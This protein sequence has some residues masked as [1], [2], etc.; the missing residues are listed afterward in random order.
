M[1]ILKKEYEL[2]VWNEELIDGIKKESRGT[3]I[4][5]S[6]MTH[7]GRATTPKL[8]RSVK[9]TNTLTFQ[10]P[11][12][13]FDSEKGD[14]VK[15][16]L[17]EDLYNERKLKLHYDGDWYEFYVKSIQEDKQFKSIMKTIT[18][19]DSFI[20]ELSRTGYEVEFSSDLNNSVEELGTF[21][22]TE[23]DEKIKG[24]SK[25][26]LDGSVWDYRPD[27]NVG[28]FTEFNEQ[29]FYKIPLSQF[30]GTIKGYKINLEVDESDFKTITEEEEK[31]KRAYL[32]NPFTKEKRPLEYGDDQARVEEL[33]YD[34]YEKDNGR[35]LLSD[36]NL[37]EISGDYIYV[38]ITDLTYIM[39]SVYKSA[40][41]SL[42][43]PAIYGAYNPKA[44]KEIYALQPVSE[45]PRDLIQ[46]LFFNE[47]DEVLIDEEGVVANK[48]CHYLITI[49][50]WN[51][52]LK[53]QLK[54][55]SEGLIHWTSPVQK[56]TETYTLNKLYTT[57]ETIKDNE[58]I[59]YTTKVFPN[60][61]TIDNFN[62]Y[63]V[64][65]EAYLDK[66][67]DE[68]VSKARKISITDRTEL[69]LNS[70]VYT[71]VYNQKDTDFKG[72]YSED[73]LNEL[74][75]RRQELRDRVQNH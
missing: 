43:E 38:P 6:G 60:T 32:R 49:E 17:L 35:S 19:T 44:K 15:N 54:N 26:I 62:L 45:N 14:Y 51:E 73:E 27:M 59:I 23:D 16:E 1:S 21:M 64:Y 11:T 33:F 36:D 72:L 22:E 9:G 61:R 20:D 39:G 56:D 13:Y 71:T 41:A 4:G 18:C 8:V 50:Q 57:T 40:S 68:E 10:M 63:H 31:E 29:R 30:G 28:D 55:N 46:F 48:N 3:T 12:K 52:A 24:S 65:Y 7:L 74:I 58:K 47:N 34:R 5:A 66:I 25:A 75:N 37:V 53:K 69:N 42:E 2:S 67:N 70:D